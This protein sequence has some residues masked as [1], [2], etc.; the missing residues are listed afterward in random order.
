[1]HPV[2][3]FLANLERDSS[4]FASEYQTIYEELQAKYPNMDQYQLE[5]WATR[6]VA[7][8]YGNDGQVS[9]DMDDP[10]EPR[11]ITLTIQCT[12]TS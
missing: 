11:T 8:C 1:M 9:L 3:S 6:M 4:H 5:Y 7:F 2:L 12:Y 10:E